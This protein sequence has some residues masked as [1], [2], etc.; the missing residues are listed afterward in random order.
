MFLIDLTYKKPLSEVERLLTNHSAFLDKY[1]AEGKII[2][3]GRKEPRTGGLILVHRCDAEEV[4]KIIGED[5]FYQNDV[6]D[7]QVQEFIPTKYAEAF[8]SFI[9]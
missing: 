8:A 4:K 1:Y 3:S 7:Y 9:K 2:F 6:A 5:P